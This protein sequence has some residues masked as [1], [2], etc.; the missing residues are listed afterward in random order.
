MAGVS[1]GT[2]TRWIQDDIIPYKGVGNVVRIN[3][4]EFIA[5]MKEE[6]KEVPEHGI[7]SRKK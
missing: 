4:E 1:V 7:H 2:I 6:C 5:W 3:R